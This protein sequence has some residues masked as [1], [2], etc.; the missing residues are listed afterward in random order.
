MQSN[1]NFTKQS[2]FTIVELLIVVV[3]IAILAAIVLVTYRSIQDRAEVTVIKSDLT[4]AAKQ[5]A[6]SKV[7][8]GSFPSDESDPATHLSASPGVVY[9]YT[10]DASSFCLSAVKGDKAYHITSSTSSQE[11][12]CAGHT[13]PGGG[14]GG[15]IADG[16]FMQVV[17][18]AN[19][20]ASRTRAVDARDN[21]TYWVQKLA[22]G[23]CWMLTNIAYAGGGTNTYG[24]VKT[25]ANGT[26][27]S[28]SSYT[29][30]RYYIPSGA[31]VTSEPTS[32][33]VSTTG[34]GQYG[35]LYNWCGAMGGQSTAAC[36]NATTPAPNVAVTT[37][38]SG[39]RLPV[40]GASDVSEFIALN[41]AI[42]G[43]ATHTDA[44]FRSAWFVQRGGRWF[45]GGFN[46]VGTVGYY[47]TTTQVSA[48]VIDVF[49]VDALHATSA[50]GALKEH[51]YAVRC[52]AT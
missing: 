38:P 41:N 50:L 23:R 44:G 5:L 1:R 37:C 36:A 47:W 20:P 2:A 26:G 4:Q 6:M 8:D 33:S 21:R 18:S 48:T 35:Y 15:V 25:L 19:C 28:T 3:V 42:N 24:D 10:A 32:P 29:A 14:S 45:G 46:N 12:V 11:G 52:I 22:D 40:G 49:G 51:A 13:A 43:G 9:E 31:N 17:T 34:T 7:V 27:D 16:S 39:W 30:P